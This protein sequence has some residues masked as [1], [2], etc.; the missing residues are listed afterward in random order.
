MSAIVECDECGATHDTGNA[1][2]CDPARR[3][4]YLEDK[5][6]LTVQ[7]LD[8]VTTS[9]DPDP[10]WNDCVA[11]DWGRVFVAEGRAVVIQKADGH[12]A[13]TRRQAGQVIEQLDRILR[14][15]SGLGK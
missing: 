9:P 15:M 2:R 11:F 5:L 14:T 13:L 10:T 6:A 3:C 4:G 12:V 8:D 7:L 1:H